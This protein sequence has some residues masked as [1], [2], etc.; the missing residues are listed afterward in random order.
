MKQFLRK[1]N[2][3]AN[4]R[5]DE[6]QRFKIKKKEM[7]ALNSNVRYVPRLQRE[8]KEIESAIEFNKEIILMLKAA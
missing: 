4:E 5:V 3:L 1:W 7:Y 8:L 6:L 2:E